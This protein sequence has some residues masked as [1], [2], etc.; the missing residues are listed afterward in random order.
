MKIK[1]LYIENKRKDVD[2]YIYVNERK[3]NEGY[4]LISSTLRNFNIEVKA[5]KK[6]RNELINLINFGDLT[7][8]V[9]T[10]ENYILNISD[11]KIICNIN[12][13]DNTLEIISF[14]NLKNT[15]V[16]MYKEKNEENWKVLNI[17]VKLNLN[18]EYDFKIINFKVSNIYE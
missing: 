2:Y 8:Q 12:T 16:V 7:V 13:T 1:N 17:S 9:S 10:G 4:E 6:G 11:E 18:N 3:V 14:N 15:Q 5:R